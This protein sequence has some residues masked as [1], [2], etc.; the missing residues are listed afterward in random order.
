LASC[1]PWLQTHQ[2]SRPD[3]GPNPSRHKNHLQWLEWESSVSY[4]PNPRSH[5]LVHVNHG[6][7]T[8][9]SQ[10]D[11]CLLA[12]LDDSLGLVWD[13]VDTYQE[14]IG[15]GSQDEESYR[16]LEQAT[17]GMGQ[18]CSQLGDACSPGQDTGQGEA[19]P[20]VS[21]TFPES[22]FANPFAVSFPGDI[23]CP[24][25]PASEMP[26]GCA[27]LGV[28]DSGDLSLQA[29]LA[30]SG[31]APS[32]RPALA[33]CFTPA[34]STT[35]KSS[36]SKVNW[37]TTKQCPG[38]ITKYG[39][40]IHFVDMADKKG[41]QRLRNTINSRRHRQNKLD[42]IRELEKKLAVI[43]AE[44]ETWQGRATGMGWKI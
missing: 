25:A 27:L 11:N 12:H 42:K 9:Q 34:T 13:D 44:K 3:T 29:S 7:R 26:V 33:S 6:Q 16:V 8:V 30:P 32:E 28:L 1:S 39:P 38:P 20:P 21:F 10:Y 17:H 18:D 5:P 41:A 36:R 22:F 4:S 31:V 43:E 23:P 19:V 14:S 37:Q 2:P 40:Q 35:G 24:G 15:D